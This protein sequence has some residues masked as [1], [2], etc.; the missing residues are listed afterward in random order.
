[1]A[2]TEAGVTEPLPVAEF[3]N[4]ERLDI[5]VGRILAAEDFPEARKPL[6][7]VTVDFGP[8]V[9][10]KKSG[11]GLRGIRT[12]EELVGRLVVAVVNFPPRQI[13][14]FLSECLILAAPVENGDLA[15]LIPEKEVPL[16][17]KIF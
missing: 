14:K 1:M 9:G 5:R 4:F 10:I 11:A 8:D 12:K 17:A 2:E 15:L 3:A 7:K 13:G 6:Y 16:G